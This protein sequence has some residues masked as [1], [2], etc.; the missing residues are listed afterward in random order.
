MPSYVCLIQFKDQGIRNIQDTVK[1][2]NLMNP[3]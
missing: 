3:L 2:G 1:R